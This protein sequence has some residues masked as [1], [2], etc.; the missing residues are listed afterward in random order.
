[1]SNTNES[2]VTNPLSG[3]VLRRA[4]TRAMAHLGISRARLAE[5]LAYARPTIS[6]YLNDRYDG[7]AEKV[8][9]ALN[10][11]LA[12]IDPKAWSTDHGDFVETP[13]AEKILSVL[14][15]TQVQQDMSLIYGG[16]GVGKTTAIRQYM[17]AY[18]ERCWLATMTPSSAGLVSALECVAVALGLGTPNGGARRI[19]NVIREHIAD[20]GGMIIIDEAQ[21]LSMAAVEELRSI[22]DSTGCGLALVGNETSYARLTGGARSAHYAQIFSR[23]GA[24]LSIGRPSELDVKA[25]CDEWKVTD[26]KARDFLRKLAMQP[27]ALRSVVKALRILKRSNSAVNVDSLRQACGILG[28]EV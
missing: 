27:G 10:A 5:L 21:H 11:W 20:G 14:S 3:D 12:S 25:I 8:E 17:T 2:K 23:I 9:A 4:V 6:G 22:H 1:M 16:P 26:A 15:Y 24:R 28:A 19:S 18:P 13:S 7:D